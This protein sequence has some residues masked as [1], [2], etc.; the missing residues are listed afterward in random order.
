MICAASWS[1]DAPRTLP[2][3]RC[4]SGI[5]STGDQ[6]VD[7]RGNGTNEH[8]EI[9]RGVGQAE[10]DDGRGHPATEGSACSPEISGPKAPRSGAT[11]A[12]RSPTGWRCRADRNREPALQCGPDGLLQLGLDP[13]IG[14]L[15]Q[16]VQWARRQVT[17]LEAQQDVEPPEAISTT[18]AATSSRIQLQSIRELAGPHP[19]A[20]D[21]AQ[22]RVGGG[23]PNQSRPVSAAVMSQWGSELGSEGSLGWLGGFGVVG[24]KN[25]LGMAGAEYLLA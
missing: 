18:T 12:S 13:A 17:A 22:V 9:H 10:P 3:L 4:C 16:H 7:D 23:P 1:R 11:W 8:H 14:E 24:Q 19:I 15:A 2:T 5:W 20:A 6:P 21:P 25:L